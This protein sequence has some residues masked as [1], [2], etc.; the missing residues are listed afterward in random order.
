[1]L[2]APASVAANL[3]QDS[4]RFAT[5][6]DAFCQ[7]FQS[8][9]KQYPFNATGPDATLGEFSEIFRP[10]NG[11]LTKLVQGTLRDHVA[12]RGGKVVALPDALP[13]V[14]DRFVDFLSRLTTISQTFYGDRESDPSFVVTV[15]GI[16]SRDAPRLT[17]SV[18]QQQA[19]WSSENAQARELT[20]SGTAA[21]RAGV[22]IAYARRA[23]AATDSSST[24]YTGPW[25][26]LHLFGD[27]SASRQRQD[28]SDLYQ[29]QIGGT[30]GLRSDPPLPHVGI[31]IERGR[32]VVSRDLFANLESCPSLV[33]R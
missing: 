18:D 19:S 5:R 33:D 17:V 25:A 10:T 28:A 1:M 12:R 7:A 16:P 8:L 11:A 26:L 23:G 21:R 9:A 3:M 30:A 24:A 27:E 6:A 13:R 4:K 29:W 2:A 14:S 22:A 20:W 32:A 31:T 15:R